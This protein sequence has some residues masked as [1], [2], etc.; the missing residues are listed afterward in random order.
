[1]HISE[2]GQ[3]LT[4]LSLGG[5]MAFA[6]VAHLTFAREEFQALVPPWVPFPADPVV[7]GSGIIEIGFGALLIALP[8]YRRP[9]TAA[10]IVFLIA[11][12]TGNL[13]QYTG[14]IDAFG[15][16]TDAKRLARLFFQPIFVLAALYAGNWF[17]RRDRV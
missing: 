12:F 13:S 4:R 8:R 16:D 10:L 5:F 1:M 6:G 2:F 9:I 7:V 17:G 11:V 14:S 15:L 3:H